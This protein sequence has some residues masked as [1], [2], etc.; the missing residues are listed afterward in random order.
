MKFDQ[1]KLPIYFVI[2]CVTV[3][4]FATYHVNCKNVNKMQE[5]CK[6]SSFIGV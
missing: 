2:Y 4:D 5:M 3:V 1:F 6:G